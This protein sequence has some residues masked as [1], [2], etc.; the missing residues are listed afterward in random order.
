MSKYQPIKVTI[1]LSIFIVQEY[2][3]LKPHL[4]LKKLPNRG[5]DWT[6]I[7]YSGKF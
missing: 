7:K 6:N 1:F 2:F 5:Y 3:T 4:N